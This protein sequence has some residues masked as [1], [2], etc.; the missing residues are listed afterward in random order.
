[1]QWNKWC[2]LNYM[3][4]DVNLYHVAHR[5]PANGFLK[6]KLIHI[7][8][9]ELDG[10]AANY[11]DRFKI[12]YVLNQVSRIS[13]VAHPCSLSL[14]LSQYICVCYLSSSFVVKISFLRN[15]WFSF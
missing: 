12:Y 13:F 7:L 15:D 6:C 2:D 5:I 3:D 11:P 10:L 14:S 4:P 8:Q 1:M 9:E